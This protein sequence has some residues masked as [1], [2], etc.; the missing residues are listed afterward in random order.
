VKKLFNKKP[1]ILVIGDL[2]IDISLEGDCN[3][4]SPEAPVQII[5]IKSK[6]VTL[7]GAGNVIKNLRSLGADFGI[8]SVIGADDDSKVIIDLLDEIKPL[9]KF[10]HL[11]EKRI[12]AKK[13]RVISS[14][15]QIIRYDQEKI[16]PI[17]SNIEDVL[18]KNFEC[19]LKDFDLVLISDYGKGVVTER[20]AKIIIELCIK[21]NIQVLVDPKGKDYS[22]YRNATLLTPN[23]KEASEA[24]GIEINNEEALTQ[25]L[26]Y[27]KEQLNI[28]Y[29]LITLSEDGIALLNGEL[30]MFPTKA[31][32]VF[33]VTG[34][35]DTVLASLGFALASECD[36]IE[37]IN[38]SNLAAGLAVEK[39]GTATVSMKEIERFHAFLS[40]DKISGKII[41][42]QSLSSLSEIIKNRN[43]KIVFTNGCFD[44]L[45]YGHLKYLE[46]AS[47][48]GQILI[49]GVNSDKSVRNLKGQ[50]RPYIPEY[51]RAYLLASLEYV[52]YV[53]IFDDPTPYEIISLIQPDVLV[54]GGDYKKSNIVGGDIVPRVE[55]IDFIEG[56]S[57]TLI[58]NKIVKS[59]N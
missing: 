51:E 18:L 9:A 48:K 58:A 44:I 13:T 49:I 6:K 14:H 4:V 37:S 20:V 50:S 56:K 7:G 8:L 21:S 54:K 53:V 31:R 25:S 45:H 39:F 22:K 23:K 41:S 46:S 30:I 35:G 52:D 11:D 28:K 42:I 59:Q 43:E 17:S 26:V 33:D 24:C 38:F 27:L 10:I 36:I 3:K 15:Q 16:I 40:E 32:D 57:T 12:S 29:P 34:A 47:K 1:K 19:L 5:D 55:T 2:M